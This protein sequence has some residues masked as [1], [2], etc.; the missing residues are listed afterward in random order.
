MLHL[1]F[2]SFKPSENQA[3]LSRGEELIEISLMNPSTDISYELVKQMHSFLSVKKWLAALVATAA[4]DIPPIILSS[5][6]GMTLAQSLDH[7]YATAPDATDDSVWEEILE[8]RRSHDMVFAF[9]GCTVP[10]ICVG[11]W[12]G[13]LTISWIGDVNAPAS[14]SGCEVSLE[15]LDVDLQERSKL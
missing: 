8:F 1:R 5:T 11:I 2:K 15:M 3:V 10:S 13:Q 12:R 9:R 7:F 6:Q 4:R 14:L